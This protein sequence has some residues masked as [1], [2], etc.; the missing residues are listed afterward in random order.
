M[1][2]ILHSRSGQ[3]YS[4]FVDMN[5]CSCRL[6]RKSGEVWTLNA[7]RSKDD[8][9]NIIFENCEMDIAVHSCQSEWR[10]EV[11]EIDVFLEITPDLI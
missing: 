7:P 10:P 5:V 4:G 6:K 11:I 2:Y 1:L 8:F 3:T 9:V